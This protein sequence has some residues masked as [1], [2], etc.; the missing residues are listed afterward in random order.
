MVLAY[1]CTIPVPTYIWA[2]KIYSN[3][4][5]EKNME[6]LWNELLKIMSINNNANNLEK[7]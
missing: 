6:K 1:T 5:C 4:E 2:N 3:L 7:K